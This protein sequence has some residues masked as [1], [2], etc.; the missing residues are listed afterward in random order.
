[1][2]CSNFALRQVKK[3]FHLQTE[4]L[5]DFFAHKYLCIGQMVRILLMSIY[6]FL[7]FVIH[8]SCKKSFKIRG[9]YQIGLR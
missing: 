7:Y 4:E 6:I 2:A 1:M 3:D 9:V 8:L 5:I